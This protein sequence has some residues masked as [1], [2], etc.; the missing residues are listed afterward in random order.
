MMQRSN[1]R[2]TLFFILLLI[3]I[4][5]NLY[6]YTLDRSTSTSNG[7]CP[8]RFPG[9]QEECIMTNMECRSHVNSS[10]VRKVANWTMWS[11]KNETK[12]LIESAF[13]TVKEN[14]E[15]FREV[16]HKGKWEGG[17]SGQGS[18]VSHDAVQHTLC[19]LHSFITQ[20]QI[21]V[22]IDLSCGDQQWAYVLRE[23]NP[24]L[25]YIGVDIVPPIIQYNRETFG[26]NDK[27]EF[28]LLD[29][30]EPNYYTLIREHSKIWPP[31]T[32]KRAMAISRHTFYH[33]SNPYIALVLRNSLP[34]NSGLTFV[35]F[36]THFAGKGGGENRSDFV[37][38]NWKPVN[39][40][41]PPFDINPPYFSW[42]EGVKENEPLFAIW[43]LKQFHPHFN[44]ELTNGMDKVQAERD[45]KS[46]RNANK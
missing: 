46:K 27:I 1:N 11:E 44:P 38:G 31:G 29:I 35:G 28:F 18:Y 3:S 6:L 34:E 33:L 22:L 2:S 32:A 5:L 37:T 12:L 20:N 7:K 21:E 17:G 19:N 42:K 16:Y 25:L 14:I 13:G 23:L 4:S 15:V 9:T 8:V 45:R 41:S 40:W 36:T 30:T 43:D 10:H 24:D 26:H 39:L